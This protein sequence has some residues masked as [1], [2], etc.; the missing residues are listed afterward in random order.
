MTDRA[1][2]P[3]ADHCSACEDCRG[4]ALPVAELSAVLDRGALTIEPARLSAHA[5]AGVV[6]LLHAR[7]QAAFWRQLVRALAA[8]LLPLP[9]LVVADWWLLGR[10]YDVAAAWLPSAVAAYLVL[11]Y[12]ASLVVLV[13]VLALVSGFRRK[14]PPY[15]AFLGHTRFT[16]YFMIAIFPMQARYLDWTWERVVAVLL[17]AFP[18][19]LLAQFGLKPLRKGAQR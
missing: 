19:W 10:V 18:V 14:Y 15:G 8:A 3:L 12:A 16:N 9:L 17:F 4:A 6:P 7:A 11:S 13:G 1:H 2:N 5:L